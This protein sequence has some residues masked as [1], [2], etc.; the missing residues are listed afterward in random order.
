VIGSNRPISQ[1]GPIEKSLAAWRQKLVIAFSVLVIFLSV[2]FFTFQFMRAHLNDAGWFQFGSYSI[3]HSQAEDLLEGRRRLFLI[4]DPSRTDLVQYPPAYPAALA[5]IYEITGNRTAYSAQIVQWFLDLVLSIVLVAGI[6]NSAFDYR[7]AFAASLLLGL[8]PVLSMYAAYPSADTPTMWFVL[9]GNWLVIIAAK[10]KSVVLALLSGVLL[11]IACWIR[12]NPLYLFIGW[13]VALLFVVN[14]NW[15]RRLAMSAALLLGTIV[16]ISPIVVRNY[17]T[18]PDFTPTGGTIGVNLW[19]GLGETELGR[20]NGFRYG[21]DK[22]L[23]V[24]RARMGIAADSRLTPQ[25]PDGIRRD[26]ERVRES[27]AFIQQHPI[28]YAGVMFRR[29]WAMLNIAGEPVAYYGSSGINVTSKKCLPENWQHGLIAFFVTALGMVQS[30]ARY[31]LLPLVVYGVFVAARRDLMSTVLLGVTVLYYLVPGSAAH[32]EIRYV[33]SMHAL[34]LVF[35][36]VGLHRL[37][38]FAVDARF[39]RS[40]ASENRSPTVSRF[41]I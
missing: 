11:G 3:F 13:G 41:L 37:L 10:R 35:A 6:A 33:I 28:W 22:M 31:L 14:T 4:D 39:D 9:A 29:M 26:R 38:K 21:D 32:T 24:E 25:W 30:V 2:R 1:I 12:V 5:T 15:K 20:Q 40:S 16:V 34:L 23:E 36:G 27:M 19:E 7:I 18:F 8:S 17:L